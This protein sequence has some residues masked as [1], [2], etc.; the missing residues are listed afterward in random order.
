MPKRNDLLIPA[1]IFTAVDNGERL[2]KEQLLTVDYYSKEYKTA[3]D[4][5]AT[6]DWLVR[7]YNARRK[8]NA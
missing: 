6:L 8:N 3:M 4:V 2:L 1:N 7:T 5:A